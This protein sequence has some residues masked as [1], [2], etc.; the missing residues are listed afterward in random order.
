[1]GELRSS[2]SIFD[3]MNR[4]YGMKT[5]NPESDFLPLTFIL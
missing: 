4:I 1:M 2:K 5:E 3:R